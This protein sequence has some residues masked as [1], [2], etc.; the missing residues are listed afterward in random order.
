MVH[1][2][3]TQHLGKGKAIP[4][5]GHEAHRVVKR[6][7]SHIFSRQLAH[8]QRLGCQPYALAA[9]YPPGRFLVIISF[10]G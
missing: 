8:R 2:G 4:V 9:L 5:T 3:T 6:R 7:G 1:A 10:R